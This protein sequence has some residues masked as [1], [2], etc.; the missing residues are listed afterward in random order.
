MNGKKNQNE[1]EKKMKKK[2]KK[3]AMCFKKKKYFKETKKTLPL[4]YLLR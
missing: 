1:C 3:S 4:R 2:K